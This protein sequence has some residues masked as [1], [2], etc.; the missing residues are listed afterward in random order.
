MNDSPKKSSEKSHLSIPLS[1]RPARKA[2][3]FSLL[4]CGSGRATTIQ[5]NLCGVRDG[6]H[7]FGEPM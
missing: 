1:S 4:L 3:L 6:M 5:R 7:F 2:T